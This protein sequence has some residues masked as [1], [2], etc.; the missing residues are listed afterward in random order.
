MLDVG[1]HSFYRCLTIDTYLLLALLNIRTEPVT[2]AGSASGDRFKREIATVITFSL[3]PRYIEPQPSGK[4]STW[5]TKYDL[6]SSSNHRDFGGVKLL[7]FITSYN[8]VDAQE[9]RQYHREINVTEG[10]RLPLS[11]TVKKVSPS[12]VS[13]DTLL[14]SIKRCKGSVIS[15]C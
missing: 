11:G 5:A 1:T 10:S 2:A 6:D 15:Y 9:G 8:F 13:E 12:L 7:I 3:S 4:R 14:S